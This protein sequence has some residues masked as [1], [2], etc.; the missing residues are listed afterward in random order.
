MHLS[1]LSSVPVAAPEDVT[2]VGDQLTVFVAHVDPE[3]RRLSLSRRH[4]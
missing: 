1:E 3:R 4:S 2:E